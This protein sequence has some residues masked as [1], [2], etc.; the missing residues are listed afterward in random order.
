MEVRILMPGPLLGTR[1]VG[2]L[3]VGLLTSTGGFSV[4]L[5]DVGWVSTRARLGTGACS[6]VLVRFGGAALATRIVGS[7]I[8]RLPLG[9]NWGVG[10]FAGCFPSFLAA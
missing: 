5:G 4:L 9:R 6:V 8:Q 1:S 7:P 10:S 3:V 2:G